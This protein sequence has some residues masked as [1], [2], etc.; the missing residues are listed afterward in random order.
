MVT[1]FAWSVVH[2]VSLV[3]LVLDLDVILTLW[4]SDR[5][6]DISLPS[7]LSSY[8][9]VNW[10][11]D[12]VGSIF[13]SRTVHT[14]LGWIINC[15]LE[16]SIG[17]RWIGIWS[18]HFEWTN[19]GWSK[20]HFKQI[21]SC[22]LHR[23]TLWD[24]RTMSSCLDFTRSSLACIDAKGVGLI[25]TQPAL[26][27]IADLA[28][29]GVGGCSNIHLEGA[30]SYRG[31]APLNI[32]HVG[33][34]VLGNVAARKRGPTILTDLD[35][36]IFAARSFDICREGTWTCLICLH[37]KLLRLFYA[38]FGQA[39]TWGY[40]LFGITHCTHER[41]TRD[42]FVVPENWDCVLTRLKGSETNIIVTIGRLL[43]FNT[44][45]STGSLYL[46]F[47]LARTALLTIDAEAWCFTNA[48]FL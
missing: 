9:E 37:L 36:N 47:K 39:R 17:N 34:L 14:H 10:L 29:R 41:T 15:E 46:Y 24:R 31:I 7:V 21:N 6:S 35:R 43:H 30:A 44:D 28:F 27:K 32:D 19:L 13:N 4:S 11:F 33:T 20:A 8:T 26:W 16:W 18:F 3:S 22:L 45:I 1:T 12:L 5:G 23:A 42:G 25:C 40:A 38:G 48:S 2:E